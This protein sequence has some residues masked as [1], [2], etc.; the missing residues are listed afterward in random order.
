MILFV[1]KRSS[2]G[3]GREYNQANICVLTPLCVCVFSA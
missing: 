2:I 1:K 3:Q